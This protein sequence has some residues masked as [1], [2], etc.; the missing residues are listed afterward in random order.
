MI[1]SRKN[2]PLQIDKGAVCRITVG[3]PAALDVDVI[4]VSSDVVAGAS[5]DV[6]AAF[7]VESV[8]SSENSVTLKLTAPQTAT[9]GTTAEYL[10]DVWIVDGA[11]DKSRLYGGTVTVIEQFTTP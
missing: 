10:Y 2:I 9:F 1:S 5:R 7:A 4:T 11:G 6:V 8:N 3:F